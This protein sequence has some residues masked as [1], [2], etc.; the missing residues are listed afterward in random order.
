MSI[1]QLN[2]KQIAFAKKQFQGFTL[3]EV[4][5]TLGIIGIVAA[6]TI[7]TLMQNTQD[8]QLKAAWKKEFS[9]VAQ[10][11]AQL[12][13]DNG[14][15]LTGLFD[16]LP[17]PYNQ[18]RD[19]YAPYFRYVKSCDNAS[20]QTTGISQC[21]SLDQK[22]LNGSPWGGYNLP[23]R[24]GLV[25][26]DGAS[27]VFFADGYNSST[28]CTPTHWCWQIWVDVN[29]LKGPNVT[30]RDIFIIYVNPDNNVPDNTNDCNS[31]GGGYGCSALYLYQ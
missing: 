23:N 15:T 10:A 5:I 12:R 14:G 16:T 20:Y 9:I 21:W 18:V 4:L 8:Q 28:F 17:S 13:N 25:L 7:P 29:G 22:Y 31:S 30:G 6:M 3:A 24:P 2:S 26:N 27:V 19:A 1:S 11:T